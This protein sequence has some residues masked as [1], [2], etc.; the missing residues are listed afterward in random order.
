MTS[1]Q[2]LRLLALAAAAALPMLP[3]TSFGAEP[4]AHSGHHP[5]HW[6]YGGATGPAQWASVDEK[7]GT[8]AIGQT[9]SPIDIRTADVQTAALPAINFDYKPTPLKIIDN[10]HT[11][12]VNVA[13]GSSITVGDSRYELLQFHFHKP[14]EERINGKAY[15]LVAHLVHRSDAGQLAVVAVLLDKGARH[16]L[17]QAVF[18]NLPKTREQETPVP[19]IG[20]DLSALLPE[21]R[22]YYNFAGSLTTP[23]C[24]EGVNWFVLKTPVQVSAEQIGRFGRAYAMNA[25]PVQPLNGR[26]IKASE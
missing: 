11:V 14:S 24:S 10:G 7:F 1:A 22:A 4:A 25:R 20:I 26:V 6:S 17:I 13:P 19:G 5:T 3:A 18:D 9:Q 21:N 2:R 16:P 23:P 8:C 15:P 12:Q